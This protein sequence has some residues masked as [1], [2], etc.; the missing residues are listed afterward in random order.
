M[1]AVS[2]RFVHGELLLVRDPEAFLAGAADHTVPC[3]VDVQSPA[4]AEAVHYGRSVPVR[5]VASGER[6]HVDPE[7]V[8]RIDA[9]ELM[10]D[11]DTAPLHGDVTALESAAVAWLRQQKGGR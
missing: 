7:F 4:D 2:E 9:A 5:A 11:I 1:P 6:R 10:R 3:R 8:R